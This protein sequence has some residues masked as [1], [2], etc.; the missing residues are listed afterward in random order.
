MVLFFSNKVDKLRGRLKSNFRILVSWED[1]C[2]WK[3]F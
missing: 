3:N 1:L 2:S